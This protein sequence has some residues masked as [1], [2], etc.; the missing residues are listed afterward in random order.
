M[1]IK[2]LQPVIILTFLFVS[3]LGLSQTLE[4]SKLKYGGYSKKKFNNAEKKIFIEKFAINYQYIYAKNKKTR[5]G[6]QMGGGYLGNAKAALF[7]GLDGIKNEE[8]QKLTDKAYE[9]FT[10]SL[11]SKGFTII[12]GESYANN[13]YYK[14][15]QSVKGGTP[16]EY[17][18]GFIS[19][20]PTNVT[21]LDKGYGIFNT[22][23]K[24]SKKLDGVIIARINI[25]VPFAEDGQS[26]GSKALAKT[27]GGI[28]KV[29]A[30]PNLRI[31]STTIQS[32]SK[33]G[34]DKYVTVNTNFDIGFQKS[35]KYQAW[36][37]TNPKKGILI[38]N[39]LPKKKYKA[40]KSASQD[41]N[42]SQVG[43]YKVFNIPDQELKK[44]QLISFDGD[45]YFNGVREAINY[46][47][48]SST[49]EFLSNIK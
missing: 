15:S 22:S 8:L 49:N 35:L 25:M 43:N 29:V 24:T 23:L 4:K 21:F 36:H 30:K 16:K 27:F 3:N 5:G 20:T 32:K 9:E 42:G 11:K 10:S 12:T 13:D 39:V 46:F 19:T 33:L 37:T 44:M 18:K 45:A 48:S 34:F 1:K 6:K 2:F 47:I 31:G 7:L 38:K 26:Q 40:V 14:D 41:L 17:Y 28:A